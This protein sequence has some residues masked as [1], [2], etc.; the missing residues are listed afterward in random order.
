MSVQLELPTNQPETLPLA[1]MV[2]PCRTCTRSMQAKYPDGRTMRPGVPKHAGHG[3]CEACHRRLKRAE[4]REAAAREA[5]AT[6]PAAADEPPAVTFPPPEVLADGLCAQADPEAWFPEKGGSTKAA[7]AICNGDDTRPPCPVRD[8]CLRFALANNER[9]GIWGGM[10]ER[11][12]RALA[13]AR[14]G[15]A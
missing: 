13:K 5:L 11:E 2:G 6:D 12:R 14:A 9:F 10:S 15:A 8:E 1:P 7:K 3:R 4:E